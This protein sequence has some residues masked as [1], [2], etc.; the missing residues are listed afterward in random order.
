[1]KFLA[2]ENFPLP[3]V[4]LIRAAG[5]EVESIAERHSGWKDV[6]VLKH[7]VENGQVILTFDRDY[8]E[9][10]FR[11]RLQPPPA[12]VFFRNKGTHPQAVAGRLM[13]LVTNRTVV[14]EG[15][16]RVI[17]DEGIRQRKLSP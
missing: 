10:L 6:E 16:F 17:I 8:G 2:N 9:L 12:V 14:L 7:A 15:S 11:Y 5:Y 1:M 3:S 13:A 4:Q